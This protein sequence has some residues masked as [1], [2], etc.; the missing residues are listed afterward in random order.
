MFCVVVFP[1]PFWDARG[2]AR[3]WHGAH[4]DFTKMFCC[5]QA[6]CVDFECVSICFLFDLSLFR[7]VY[8]GEAQYLEGEEDV[9]PMFQ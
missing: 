6:N 7:C 1:F 8:R 5:F 2:I 9:D 3:L 4:G